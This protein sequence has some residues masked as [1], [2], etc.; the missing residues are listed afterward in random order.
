MFELSGGHICKLR[1][2]RSEGALLRHNE[3]MTAEDVRDNF[4]LVCD[5]SKSHPMT[6]CFLYDYKYRILSI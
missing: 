6:V 5:F 2:E 3:K 4:D 1:W